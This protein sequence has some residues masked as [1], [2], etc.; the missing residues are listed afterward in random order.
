MATNIWTGGEDESLFLVGATVDTTSG[1]YRSSYTREDIKCASGI[2]NGIYA[3]TPQRTLT[4][5]WLTAQCYIS[6]VANNQIWLAFNDSSAVQR[7]YLE[8]ANA[9]NQMLLIKQNAVGSKTT[10]LTSS[11]NFPSTSGIVRIDIFIDYTTTGNTFALFIGGALFMTYTGDIT[12]DSATSLSTVL[13]GSSATGSGTG[14]SELRLQDTDTRGIQF[15]GTLV[16]AANGNTDAWDVG[17][18]TNINPV[19]INPANN[20]ASGTATQLQEYTIATPPTGNYTLLDLVVSTQASVGATGPQNIQMDV[21]T[22]GTSYP[23]SDASPAPA[24]AAAPVQTSIPLNPNTGIAWT[25]ADI[26]NV[27][28]NIG[29]KSAA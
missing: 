29:M 2:Q 12:T 11:A 26:A 4:S 16:P 8:T 27:G 22:G 25:E 3:E 13:F 7:L 15:I 19:T 20:N 17:G 1:H 24:T 6:G 21:R 18:V 28:F 5:F 10:L 9:S 23:Q 14:W